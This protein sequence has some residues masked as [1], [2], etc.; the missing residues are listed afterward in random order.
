MNE[1]GKPVDWWFMYKISGKATTSAGTT[2]AKLPNGDI[3]QGIEYVY[4]DSTDPG[5]A[6]LTLSS[7]RVTTNGA[8]PNTL[9]QVYAASAGAN[10]N[11]G[12]FFYNDQSPT[13][14]SDVGSR[15]HTKGVLAFDLASNTA[16]WLVQS[17]PKFPAKGKYAYPPSGKPNAQTLL[18]VTLADA[19]VSKELARQ[20]FAIQEPNVYAQSAIPTGLANQPNDP[21]VK[22]LKNLVASGATPMDATIPFRSKGGVKFMSIAKNRTWGLDFYND[23]VGPRLHDDLDVE[24]W[25]HDPTPPPADSDKI[26]KIVD[27]KGVDLKSLGLDL[28]WPEPDDHAKLAISA[29]SEQKHFICVGDI[30]FTISMRKRGGGTVA[31]KCE[32]LWES[33]SGILCEVYTH[34]VKRVGTRGSMTNPPP[35]KRK[36][37]AKKR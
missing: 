13:S 28:A 33:I 32:P 8:L 9:D 10:K 2:P 35:K 12:W 34:G 7:D 19:D 26:H 31:F 16:F 6:K 36:K 17:V 4:F 23:L 3:V 14:K 18:C 22:L 5:T 20:M 27:M 37:K 1:C 24:T 21:R 29:R 11:L 15:G 25:E 30:N